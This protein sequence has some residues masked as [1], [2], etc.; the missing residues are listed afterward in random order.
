MFTH[1]A[2]VTDLS[3][4]REGK[5]MTTAG[6]DGLVKI[7][8]L[9]MFKTLHSFRADAPVTSLDTSDSGLL[10]LGLGREVQILKDPFLKP[11]ITGN[12][13]TYMKHT[14]NAVGAKA[15]AAG[16]GSAITAQVRGLASSIHVQ[17]V[18]FRPYED[19][20]AVSHSHGLTS[21]VVPGAGEANFDSFESNPFAN[22]K[23]TREAEVQSLLHKLQPEMIGLD[24]SFVGSVDKDQ[25]TLRQEHKVVFNLANG[26]SIE[27]QGKKEGTK[28]KE[29]HKMRGRNKI[30]AKL[31]RKQK[32]VVDAQMVKLKEQQTSAA[33][34]RAVKLE[35]HRGGDGSV[36]RGD[37]K[38]REGTVTALKRFAEPVKKKKK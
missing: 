18:K 27:G 26:T 21:I 25:E 24:A 2:P 14:I 20:L 5:Y 30:A 6:L 33:K 34:E 22:I 23:Q 17:S 7:W 12:D 16:G 32:N 4:D 10:A 1:K 38:A 29:K 13:M 31:R 11:A 37:E 9:R 15:A 36:A 35:I 3:I 8:D 19:I 28:M